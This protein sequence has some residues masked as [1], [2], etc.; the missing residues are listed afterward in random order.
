MA[1]T[2]VIKKAATHASNRE[3]SME[4]MKKKKNK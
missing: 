4:T 2:K 3:I 1:K